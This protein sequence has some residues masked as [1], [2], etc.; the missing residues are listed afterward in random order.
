MVPDDDGQGF[1]PFGS[2]VGKNGGSGGYTPSSIYSQSDWQNM[3][4]NE[5]QSII[6]SG[7]IYGI[8]SGSDYITYYGGKT[9]D[10]MDEHY[11]SWGNGLGGDTY[12]GDTSGVGE[13]LAYNETTGTFYDPDTEG[14]AYAAGGGRVTK[15][16]KLTVA[17]DGY[18]IVIMPDGK[19]MLFTKE[20]QT[21][22]PAGA[23]ILP[24]SH[25]GWTS[26][27]A[28]S[29]SGVGEGAGLDSLFPSIDIRKRM[30]DSIK[31][32]TTKRKSAY[33]AIKDQIRAI[34][35]NTTETFKSAGM[36]KTYT[37]RLQESDDALDITSRN[38]SHWNTKTVGDAQEMTEGALESTG[39]MNYGVN[40]DF[41]SMAA[42]SRS[43]SAE[44]MAN[45]Q[46]MF[47]GIGQMATEQAAVTEKACT[48]AG[49]AVQQ[50]SDGWNN[51]VNV[52][53]QAESSGCTSGACG[54]SSGGG[55]GPCGM[56]RGN[57]Y[58]DSIGPSWTINTDIQ[59]TPRAWPHLAGGGRITSPGMAMVGEQGP[60]IVSLSK[61]ASVIPINKAGKGGGEV[62]VHIGT[63]VADRAGLMKL[64]KE[65]SKISIFE[66]ARRGVTT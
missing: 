24:G 7:Q 16:G 13:G 57:Q 2:N 35:D 62:H 3:D 8:G 20:Q 48:G 46:S 61:G 45:V 6:D 41:F 49:C 36:H 34:I 31:D 60:E 56:G 32:E 27:D 22:L 38:L 29:Q 53:E 1:V 44:I 51:L 33:D 66:D 10:Y 11:G 14:K 30:T 47:E 18:E 55:T 15:A 50:L 4:A 63:L 64:W 65:L 58:W 42:V 17:E 5:R 39:A 12:S 21:E 28:L 25:T 37:G 59:W 26:F 54:F 52:F 9:T 43:S 40:N 23:K 19:R